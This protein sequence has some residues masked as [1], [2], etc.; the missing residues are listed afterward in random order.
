MDARV[1]EELGFC[2]MGVGARPW[3]AVMA[4]ALPWVLRMGR[5]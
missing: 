3:E 2:G 1:Q 4:T 5:I